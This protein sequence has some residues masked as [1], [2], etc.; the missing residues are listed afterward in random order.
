MQTITR[1]THRYTLIHT[2][3]V[4]PR[5]I[6]ERGY[7]GTLRHLNSLFPKQMQTVST[8]KQ[9]RVVFWSRLPLCVRFLGITATI[10]VFS[11]Y[12]KLLVTVLCLPAGW[13][14]WVG[15]R[16][17]P[18]LAAEDSFPLSLDCKLATK[19]SCGRRCVC[20]TEEKKASGVGGVHDSPAQ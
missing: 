20:H 16:N 6:R 5:E 4:F 3:R 7:F 9:L 14:G 8:R 1:H 2:Q 12:R 15:A 10:S 13:K 19:E 11:S 17:A 18:S